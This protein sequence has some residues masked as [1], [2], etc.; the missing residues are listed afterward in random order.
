MSAALD[1][2]LARI[3]SGWRS[4][5]LPPAEDFRRR[6]LILRTAV[7]SLSP[8]DEKLRTAIM[9]FPLVDDRLDSG[10]VGVLTDVLR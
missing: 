5:P 1:L 9:N 8:G 3:D 4:D 10:I 7:E 2:L 6:V